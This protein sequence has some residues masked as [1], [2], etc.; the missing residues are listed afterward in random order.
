MAGQLTVI[1]HLRATLP[2]AELPGAVVT[3]DA[4]NVIAL[5]TRS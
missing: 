1:A 5:P 3:T 4:S 2:R